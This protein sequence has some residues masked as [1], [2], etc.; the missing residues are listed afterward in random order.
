MEHPD[1]AEETV[2]AEQVAERSD[3]EQTGND[4][5]KSAIRADEPPLKSHAALLPEWDG[6]H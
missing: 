4:A 3:H 5:V 2:R 1:L 6:G